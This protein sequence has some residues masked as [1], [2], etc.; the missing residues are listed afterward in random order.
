MSLSISRQNIHPVSNG[1]AFL[2]LT[3][4]AGGVLTGV[5]CSLDS[6][7]HHPDY[8]E[9]CRFSGRLERTLPRALTVS[10]P[11][12][13]DVSLTSVSGSQ[14]NASLLLS[15]ARKNRVISNRLDFMRVHSKERGVGFGDLCKA[16]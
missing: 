13:P 4:H 10:S 12:T 15:G 9:L 8:V 14:R 1:G 16:L 2:L 5:G 3:Q 6:D 7:Q 11:T